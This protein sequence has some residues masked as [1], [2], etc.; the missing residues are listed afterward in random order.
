MQHLSPED[1]QNHDL[2][3]EVQ[4]ACNKAQ[5]PVL[6]SFAPLWDHPP[7]VRVGC[8]EFMA[9]LKCECR[10]LA[11]RPPQGKAFR[12]VLQAMLSVPVDPSNLDQYEKWKSLT[13]EWAVVKHRTALEAPGQQVVNRM[14]K[15]GV[16]GYNVRDFARDAR[17]IKRDLEEYD[18]GEPATM[19]AVPVRSLLADAPVGE[20]IVVPDGWTLSDEGIV[21]GGDDGVA[22][23]PAPILITE[24]HVD[25]NGG[26]QLVTVAWRRDEGWKTRVVDRAAIA[27]SR[28][29]VD[30]LA[31]YGVPVTS[32]NA[33]SLVQYLA[34][35]ETANLEPLPVTRVSKQ[36]GWQG[37]G[38]ELGFL[39]G[40]TLIAP[41]R[42]AGDDNEG[43]QG[44]RFCGA[45]E[46]DDQIAAG[47]HKKGSFKQWKKAIG[48]IN[49]FPKVKLALYASFA[50]VLL[51]IFKARNFVVDFSGKTTAGKTTCL[52]IAASAWGDP[53]DRN[54]A[55]LVKTWDATATF[56]E[57]L[58]AVLNHLPCLLDDT[59]L[60]QQ[61]LEVARTIYSAV[62]GQARGRGSVRGMARLA[63]WHTVLY[64]SGEQPATSFTKDGGTRARVVSLWGSPFK[65]VDAETRTI[66]RHINDQLKRHYGH[67]GPRMV[68]YVLDHRDQWNAWEEEYRQKVNEYEERA[69]DNP[70]A[71]RMATDFA[72]IA[73]AARIAHEALDLPWEFEDPIKPLWKQ[74]AKESHSADQATAALRYVIDWANSHQEEFFGRAKPS[75]KPLGKG[76]TRE[77]RQP[78]GGWAGRWD[79]NVLLPQQPKGQDNWPW[80]G[81]IPAKL[82]SILRDDDFEP[83]S[84]LRMWR[85]EK[86]LATTKEKSVTRHQVKA[87][88]G[89]AT[90]WMIAITREAVEKASR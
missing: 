49:P 34:D 79:K 56:R 51:S 43:K 37:D 45:D 42:E 6:V 20:E 67:A 75:H 35:F 1:L 80:I 71:G 82:H 16:T 78:H 25:V 44:V 39:W 90:A 83:D 18:G 31:P 2:L 38:G 8:L 69:G 88:V 22:S 59:K 40:T 70:F 7:E 26:T 62:Q 65:K 14:K 33:K 11:L 23:I 41:K 19:P 17:E 77:V 87:R 29:I 4:C 32:N 48:K 21:G 85:D 66:V 63:T 61:P 24:R 72:A 58:P 5:E 89:E 84:V 36:L 60:A 47:F 28:E 68:R 81:F 86:W 27:S 52:R 3:D 74:L 55:G 12:E 9:G 50:S 64:T 15:L 13:L 73:V 76:E 57:R 30:A 53:D 46:G 10:F 54:P